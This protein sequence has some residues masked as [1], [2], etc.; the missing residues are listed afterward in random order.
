MSK[1]FGRGRVRLVSAKANW[2]HRLEDDAYID[3]ACFDLQQS[4][5]F[6]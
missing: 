6:Y 4:M 2:S 1:L 3:A 5:G